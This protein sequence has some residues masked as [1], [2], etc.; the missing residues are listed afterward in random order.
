MQYIHR[1]LILADSEEEAI[2]STE[3]YLQEQGVRLFDGWTIHEVHPAATSRGRVP[4]SEGQAATRGLMAHLRRQLLGSPL[5][6]AIQHPGKYPEVVTRLGQWAELA[7]E[8]HS[9]DTYFFNLEA[10]DY[11]TPEDLR[12][13]WVVILDGHA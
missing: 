3:E 6:E 2:A 10:G 4:I 8:R 11:S 5:R 9:R 12:G 1:L 7:D 13:H